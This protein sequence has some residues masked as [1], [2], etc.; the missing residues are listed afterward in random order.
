MKTL[1]K[2]V[3]AAAVV[4]GSAFAFQAAPAT[5]TKT[6]TTKEKAAPTAPPSDADVAAAN[7]RGDVWLNTSTKVYHKSS[8][9]EYGKTKRGAFMS[10][11]DAQKAGGHLS[12]E[13]AVKTKKTDK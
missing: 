9:K 2:I 11:A 7:K 5:A 13:G 3:L 12:K 1:L 6:T 8:D 10:E 4:T